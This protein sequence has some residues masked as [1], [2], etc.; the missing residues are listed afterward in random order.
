MDLIPAEFDDL[1][2]GQVELLI[3]GMLNEVNKYYYDSIRKSILDYV[4]KDEEEK[5]RIGIME[6]FKGV[7][8]YGERIY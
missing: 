5:L 2:K 6:V 4:L 1:E 3:D 7:K 8:D